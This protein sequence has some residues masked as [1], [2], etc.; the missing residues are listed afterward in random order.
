MNGAVSKTVGVARR[1]WVRI[2]PPPLSRDA[3]PG[4]NTSTGHAGW[5]AP[6]SYAYAITTFG[7]QGK[8]FDRA[9]PLLDPDAG[10]EEQLVAMSRG[11]E[12][13]NAYMVAASEFADPEIG[14]AR[15]ELSDALHDVRLSTEREGADVAAKEI[16]VRR[17]VEAYG[18]AGL[19]ERRRELVE[20]LSSLSGS[21]RPEQLREGI[22][23]NEGMLAR[24]RE[25]RETLEAMADPPRAELARAREAETS[26]A[27][28]L[29]S[30]RTELEAALAEDMPASQN[31]GADLR[32]EAALVD[33][34]IERLALAEVAVARIGESRLLNPVLGP[35]PE[36]PERAAAWGSAA[37]T[38]AS[39]H[40]RHGI[41]DTEKVLGQVPRDPVAR[42]EHNLAS[43]RLATAFE[44]LQ[45]PELGQQLDLDLSPT[46]EL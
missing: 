12:V 18:S 28:R 26:A 7:S 40:L 31:R 1:S 35:F 22:E 13:A 39:Y 41:G 16:E 33:A 34:Q 44:V 5:R 36:D 15:R 6:S 10:M 23:R 32:L 38:I 9:Y 19:A 25:R 8:T 21:D 11:R 4:L 20:T 2:P 43:E 42:E 29:G 30:R 46:L 3:I 14:S 45:Q 37:Y 24:L 27:E 17:R